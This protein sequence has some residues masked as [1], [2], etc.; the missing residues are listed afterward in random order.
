MTQVMSVVDRK[1]AY[2]EKSRKYYKKT[3]EYVE[4][5]K[6]ILNTIKTELIFF[7]RDNFDFGSIFH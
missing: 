4:M 1:V 6:L 3:E 2:M 5:S 7:S